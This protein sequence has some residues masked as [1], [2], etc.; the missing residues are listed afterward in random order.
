MALPLF[1]CLV[2]SSHI[3]HYANQLEA[4]ASAGEFR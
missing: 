1:T 3:V 4:I 2:N